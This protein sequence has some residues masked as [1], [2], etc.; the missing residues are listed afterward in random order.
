MLDFVKAHHLKPI[1]LELPLVSDKYGFGGT[2]DCY[3]EL[4]GK[5]AL[6]DFKTSKGV[7]PEMRVQVAAYAELLRENG[8][9][10]EEV[11]LLRIDKESGEFHHHPFKDLS[12][13][14]KFFK[15]LCQIYPLK[16]VIWKK[17]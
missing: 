5:L 14:W 3:A 9:K 16:S 12:T 7:W 15:G 13:E 10:V 1:H 17:R 6:I 8:H 11:H 4:D 2:I